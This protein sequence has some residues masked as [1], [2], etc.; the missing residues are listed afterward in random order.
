MPDQNGSD[1][2][3]GYPQA[4]VFFPVTTIVNAILGMW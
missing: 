4:V 3:L 1:M 2:G